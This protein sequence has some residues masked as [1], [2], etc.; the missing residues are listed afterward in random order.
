MTFSKPSISSPSLSIFSLNMAMA[1]LSTL[2]CEK[3][4][5]GQVSTIAMAN[6]IIFFIPGTVLK[7]KR[8]LSTAQDR[9]AL[10]KQVTS[11]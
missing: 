2:F 1:I 6:T 8:F 9:P 11:G 10:Q 3:A 5:K 4:R 7:M